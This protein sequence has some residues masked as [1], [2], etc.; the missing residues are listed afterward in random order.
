MKGKF[1]GVMRSSIFF[2]SVLLFAACGGGDDGGGGPPPNADV[3]GV[4]SGAVTISG[5]PSAM[6]GIVT[7]D[8]SESYNRIERN[9]VVG[10]D[11]GDGFWLNGV[12]NHV[13]DNVVGRATNGFYFP[14]NLAPHH[15]FRIPLTRG[16]DPS[17]DGQA[18]L[19]SYFTNPASMARGIEELPRK[20]MTATI[21]ESRS[22]TCSVLLLFNPN[23]WKALL[24]P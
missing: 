20:T 1:Q 23:D 10:V 4:W 15:M 12:R 14:P 9:F 8:G 18:E 6:V 24:T 7:E 5:E 22:I 19:F 2:S 11:R 17:V 21:F 3:G 13:V 16:A